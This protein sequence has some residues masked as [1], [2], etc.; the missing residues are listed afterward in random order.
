MASTQLGTDHRDSDIDVAIISSG[1]T[2]D[3][4]EDHREVAAARL[5]SDVRIETVRFRAEQ[6]RDENPLAWEI[7]QKG[8][9]IA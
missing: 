8:I 9:R 2:G 6:F 7:K 4:L 5:K 1:F 3:W